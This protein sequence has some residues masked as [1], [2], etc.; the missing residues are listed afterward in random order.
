ML[1]WLINY[2]RFAAKLLPRLDSLSIPVEQKEPLVELTARCLHMS[3]S[4]LHRVEQCHGQLG[5]L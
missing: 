5:L 2:S 1:K 4:K 3:I